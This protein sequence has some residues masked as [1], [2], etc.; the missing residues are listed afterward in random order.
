MTYR[1]YSIIMLI[2]SKPSIQ[3]KYENLHSS[4][5]KDIIGTAV[6]CIPECQ[7]LM[8]EIYN[9]IHEIDICTFE[10]KHT[11]LGNLLSIYNVL[12]PRLPQIKNSN[13]L[14]IMQF[15]EYLSKNYQNLTNS[16]I[17]NYVDEIYT[18]LYYMT[19]HNLQILKMYE[20]VLLKSKHN[21]NSETLFLIPYIPLLSLGSQHKMDDWFNSIWTENWNIA[22]ILQNGDDNQFQLII[23]IIT[24]N[25]DEP[26]SETIRIILKNISVKDMLNTSELWS[27]GWLKIM[28]EPYV[29]ILE[30]IH[31][32]IDKLVDENS[33]I[34][35]KNM[36]TKILMIYYDIDMLKSQN[37]DRKICINYLANKLILPNSS[38][39]VIEYNHNNILDYI[40][41]MN[42]KSLIL[43]EP[44]I[45]IENFLYT[46]IN[47][48]LSTATTKNTQQIYNKFLKYIL[49]TVYT[50]NHI[51][52]NKIKIKP[53]DS[54]EMQQHLHINTQKPIKSRNSQHI[55]LNCSIVGI[56]TL[57]I[58]QISKNNITNINNQPDYNDTLSLV[59][60]NDYAFG[61]AESAVEE[62]ASLAAGS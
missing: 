40:T 32:F 8:Q 23:K 52:Y 4:L 3:D 37:Q 29:V 5:A 38:D 1:Y 26:I 56:L 62:D 54:Q 7:E 31:I 46:M 48:D 34:Y 58:S 55:L 35:V 27:L 2:Y 25:K 13:F 16:T 19:R 30:A 21:Y 61:S 42:K 51:D 60:S 36:C 43:E 12:Q 45:Y 18:M 33:R 39:K 44:A 20:I 57:T 6:S 22:E 10:N 47:K 9:F 53:I 50:M 15:L 24:E 49:I 11:I 28:H 59:A 14:A 41:I 17:K